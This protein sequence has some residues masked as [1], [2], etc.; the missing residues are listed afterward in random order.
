MRV[1][2][3]NHFPKAATAVAVPSIQ[4]T[5]QLGRESE[6]S[7]TLHGNLFQL[8]HVIA[9]TLKRVLPAENVEP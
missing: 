2:S 8:T 6:T 1:P 4:T 5:S 9:S 7:Y 3:T